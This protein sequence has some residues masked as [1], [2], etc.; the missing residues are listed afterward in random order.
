[1]NWDIS[2]GQCK[3]VWGR[4]LQDMGRRFDRRRLVL[5]GERFEFSGRLQARYGAL[6]HQAQWGSALIRIPSRSMATEGL[7]ERMQNGKRMSA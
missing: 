5:D 6:K 7:K 4:V 1:M 2:I 3:Q